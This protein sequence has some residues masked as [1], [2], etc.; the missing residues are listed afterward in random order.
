[1]VCFA[2]NG[3]AG[4]A[5]ELSIHENEFLSLTSILA[6]NQHTAQRTQHG[7]YHAKSF[8]LGSF[9]VDLG[10]FRQWDAR[11]RRWVTHRH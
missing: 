9:R 5:G 7:V 3:E 4:F 10:K 2:Q 6:K 8:N 11:R 1:V